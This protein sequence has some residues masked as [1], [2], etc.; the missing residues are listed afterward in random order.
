MQNVGVVSSPV[1]L[2][3]DEQHVS[4]ASAPG[5]E[6]FMHLVTYLPDEVCFEQASEHPV[7][8]LRRT[9]QSKYNPTK[10][11]PGVNN[12]LLEQPHC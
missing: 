8:Q 4:Q 5:V 2:V 12:D 11:F 9:F 6:F 3:A 10:N 1:A 7:W